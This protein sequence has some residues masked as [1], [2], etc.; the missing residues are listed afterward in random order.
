[1]GSLQVV[2]QQVQTDLLQAGLPGRI[3]AE[4]MGADQ[5]KM[6]EQVALWLSRM[7]DDQ[8]GSDKKRELGEK[9]VF[10]FLCFLQA[11]QDDSDLAGVDG[12]ALKAVGSLLQVQARDLGRWISSFKPRF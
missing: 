9:R 1:M 8:S 5:T 12:G 10:L 3:I 11:F 2:I 6:K 7:P 4:S